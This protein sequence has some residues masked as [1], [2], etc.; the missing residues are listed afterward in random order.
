MRFI[1]FYLWLPFSEMTLRVPVIGCLISGFCVGR[2]RQ[3]RGKA[4]QQGREFLVVLFYFDDEG[5]FFLDNTLNRG[6]LA[7]TF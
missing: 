3:V 4:V 2:G 6:L 7:T 5:L 1:G